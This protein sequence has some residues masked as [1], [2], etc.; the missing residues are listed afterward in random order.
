MHKGRLRYKVHGRGVWGVGVD[1]VQ[2]GRTVV[3][4]LVKCL[5]LKLH[6][7]QLASVLLVLR[8]LA[9]D[10]RGQAHASH[11][12]EHTATHT[13]QQPL[14]AAFFLRAAIIIAAAAAAATP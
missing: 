3:H 10:K 14:P 1:W 4:V 9:V 6:L 13:Q 7:W 5:V 12:H 11:E 8:P 2:Q